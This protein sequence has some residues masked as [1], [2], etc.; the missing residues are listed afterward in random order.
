MLTKG[1]EEEKIS[2]IF[3]MV[4]VNL[5]NNQS[6]K[7]RFSE[8]LTGIFKL[9]LKKGDNYSYNIKLLAEEL[10]NKFFL[11]F[12][13]QCEMKS[14]ILQEEFTKWVFKEENKNRVNLNRMN[15]NLQIKT[16]EVS[17]SV[18][19]IS[20]E[21][22]SLFDKLRSTDCLITNI[23][24]YLKSLEKS[25]YLNNINVLDAAEIFKKNSLLGILNKSQIFQCFSDIYKLIELKTNLSPNEVF[26]QS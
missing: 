5:D 3:Q 4:N 9:Y 2:A 23:S 17:K 19:L 12:N 21:C 13:Y 18:L 1:N 22:S 15:S 6:K 20:S 11:K 26:L 25:F 8:I 24:T 14:D 7:I 16:N 10:T